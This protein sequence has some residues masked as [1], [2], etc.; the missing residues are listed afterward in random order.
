MDKNFAEPA[1]KD[2]AGIDYQDI[3]GTSIRISGDQMDANLTS[4]LEANGQGYI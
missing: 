4:C 1:G 2:F 3:R